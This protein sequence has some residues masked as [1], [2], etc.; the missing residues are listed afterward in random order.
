MTAQSFYPATATPTFGVNGP[1]LA[2]TLIVNKG[3]QVTMHVT[4]N[5]NTSTTMHWHGLHVP[6][7]DDGGPHQVIFAGT[8]WS[9]D[10][11][12]KNNAGT[13]WYHPHGDRKTDL[14]VSKGIAGMIIVHDSAE[15]QLDLPRTDRKSVV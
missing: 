6:P 11:E 2:P 15:M 12:I 4:N 14:Q 1:F 5:L 10:F 9:P 13:F 7:Q 3:D 8:T